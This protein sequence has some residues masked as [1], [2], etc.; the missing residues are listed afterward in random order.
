MKD[1]SRNSLNSCLGLL[2]NMKA[3]EVQQLIAACRRRLNYLPDINTSEALIIPNLPFLDKDI[4]YVYN[5]VYSTLCLKFFILPVMSYN[6]EEIVLLLKELSSKFK[7]YILPY[8]DSDEEYETIISSY[9]EKGIKFYLRTNKF[10]EEFPNHFF[11]SHLKNLNQDFLSYLL[12][13][14]T[15]L[16]NIENFLVLRLKQEN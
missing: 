7:L 10:S 15:L 12:P 14:D 3:T 4:E 9:V 6:K 16:L 8:V 1:E 11:K 13:R 5:L 2:N